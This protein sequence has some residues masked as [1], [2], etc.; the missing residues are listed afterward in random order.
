MRDITDVLLK[1]INV[2]EAHTY[3]EHQLLGTQQPS[4][5]MV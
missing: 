4:I 2:R 3:L 1:R 5:L